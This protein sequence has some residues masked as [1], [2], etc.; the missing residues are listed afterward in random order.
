M[1]VV[2]NNMADTELLLELKGISFGFPEKEPLYRQ[3]GL[4]L[5]KGQNLG[6]WSPNGSGK[7]TLFKIITGLIQPQEGEIFLKGK[8]ISSESDFRELRS[9]VG[10]FF[11]IP[12]T[13]YFFQRSLTMFL[14][15]L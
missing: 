3:T 10:L 8:P 7:T 11:S 1:D 4:S 6:F 13:N 15:D 12:M 14:S 9:K 2:K 5:R